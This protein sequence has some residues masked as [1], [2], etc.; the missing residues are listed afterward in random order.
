MPKLSPLAIQFDALLI[1]TYPSSGPGASVLVQ[2]AGKTLLR[3]G[4]GLANIELNV[5]IRPDTYFRLGSITKQFTAVGILMFY[6]Q[7]KLDLEDEITRFLPDYPTRGEA[8]T[9]RHLLTH[10]SGIPS[11]TDQPEWL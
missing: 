1:E 3:K 11:Y 2:K 6:E 10:T 8:I 5:P 7:G 9:I 4:Y